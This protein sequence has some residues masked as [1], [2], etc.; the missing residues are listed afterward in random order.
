MAPVCR[1]HP[2]GDF[3]AAWSEK[4]PGAMTHPGP[5]QNTWDPPLPPDHAVSDA[6]VPIAAVLGALWK[7]RGFHVNPATGAPGGIPQRAIPSAGACYPVQVHLLCGSDCDVPPGIHA[8]NPANSTTYRRIQSAPATAGAIVVFTVLPQR[9]AAKYHHRALP[10]LLA[11]TAYALVGV[12]RHAASRGMASRWLT[13]DPATLA[14]A[15]RVPEYSQWQQHWPDTGAELALAALSMGAG[16]VLPEL[17]QWVAAAGP[18]GRARPVPQRQ[19][20]TLAAA[21]RWATE[22]GLRHPEGPLDLTPGERLMEGQL[23]RRRSIPITGAVPVSTHP[24]RGAAEQVWRA[25]LE[26]FP[27]PMPAACEVLLVD[28]AGIRNRLL[29]RECAGQRWVDSLD[30]ILLFRTRS[31]PDETAMWWAAASA[32]HL[33]YSSLSTDPGITFRPVAGW[34]GTRDGFTTLHALGF[35]AFRSEGN[36]HAGQ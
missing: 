28:Q 32:A 4:V 34:T 7:T 18:A 12:A 29:R 15:A 21:E 23:L 2:A 5:R 10:L 25:M 8:Y 16:D 3:T 22:S 36:T 27:L 11:D 26:D 24:H 35:R 33:L 1:T 9:T 31:A 13:A 14:A 20:R 19:L 6:P 17:S 30:G